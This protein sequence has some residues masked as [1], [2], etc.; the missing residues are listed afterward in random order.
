MSNQKQQNNGNGGRQNQNGQGKRKRA[1]G[2]NGQPKK[3]RKLNNGNSRPMGRAEYA[4]ANQFVERPYREPRVSRNTARK[5]CIGQEEFLVNVTGTTAFAVQQSFALN[6]GLAAS[7]PWLSIEAQGWERY[8]FK[9][10]NFRYTTSTGSTTPGTVTMAPDY[11]AADAPPASEQVALTYKNREYCPPWEL[12]KLCRLSPA[13]MN[14]AFKEHF[15]RVGPIGANQDVK[16]YDVGNLHL[17]TSGGTAVQWGKVFVEYEVE[18]FNP[19][20]PSGG[21]SSASVLV[22]AGGSLAAATPFGAV[23]VLSGALT[24]AMPAKTLSISGLMI[25]QEFSVCIIC[26]GTGITAWNA[27][28]AVTGCVAKSVL[29]EGIPAAATS[30]A[31]CVTF[32]ATAPT[33]TVLYN[34]T[35]TTVTAS[36]AIVSILAPVPSI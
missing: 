33:A 20:L 16:T 24:L 29:Y 4:P 8:R 1:G 12:D 14:A 19:Q 7:F 31:S 9:K 28:G 15:V 23:P 26:A 27:N 11:D 2:Q 5:T 25:G 13:M 10:L 22:G 21:V 18:F 17:C 35:A 3:K 6:P 32:T 30:G 34:V 36:E